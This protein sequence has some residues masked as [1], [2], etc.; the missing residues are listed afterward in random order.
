MRKR[1]KNVPKSNFSNAAI[2]CNL[3]NNDFQSTFK[4]LHAFLS[5][6]SLGELLITNIFKNF[7]KKV[8]DDEDELFLPNCWPTKNIKLYFHQKIIAVAFHHCKDQAHCDTWVRIFFK[9][10]CAA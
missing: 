8:D 10:N 5:I 9:Q 4:V 2:Y 1:K 6:R 3:V 7:N